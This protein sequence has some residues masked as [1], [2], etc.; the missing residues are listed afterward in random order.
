MHQLVLKIGS[1][2]GPHAQQV[3]QGRQVRGS[4]WLVSDF[5]GLPPPPPPS[6]QEDVQAGPEEVQELRPGQVDRRRAARPERAGRH[7]VHGMWDND[8]VCLFDN[9]PK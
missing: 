6:Q 1:H 8:C 2:Q 7:R 5:F 3:G 4:I 9:P